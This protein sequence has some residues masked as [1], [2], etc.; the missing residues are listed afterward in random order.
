MAMLEDPEFN[1]SSQLQRAVLAPATKGFVPLP[2]RW[3]VGRT[4]TKPG[5][6]RRPSKDYEFWEDPSEPMV[7]LA[8][9]GC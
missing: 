2:R 6:S 1:T 8:R 3:I 7:Y 9:S 4:F 5:R